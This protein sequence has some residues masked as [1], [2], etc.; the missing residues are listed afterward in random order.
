MSTRSLSS[1]LNQT[2]LQNDQDRNTNKTKVICANSLEK[3]WGL[4]EVA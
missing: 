4:G 1:G 2:N 3:N